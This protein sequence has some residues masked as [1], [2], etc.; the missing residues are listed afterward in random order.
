VASATGSAGFNIPPGAAPTTPVNGDIWETSAGIFAR[1]NGA[2]VGPLISAASIPSSLPPNGSAGGDL[3]GSYP[4]PTLAWLSRT[5]GKT[6]AIAASL[7]L[8]GTDGSTL[9]VG[10]GGTLGSNAF[11]STAFAPIAS[12]TFTGTPAAPT[13]ALR[14]S[15]TQIAT[16]AFVMQNEASA[17]FYDAVAQSGIDNTGAADVGATINS[18]FATHPCIALQP[19]TYKTSVAIVI[20]TLC[21]LVGAGIGKTIITSTSTT[22]DVVR[23]ADGGSYMLARDFS[24]TRSVTPTNGAGFAWGTGTIV[25]ESSAYNI[26]SYGNFYGFR[27]MATDWS[28]MEYC[29]AY[30]N[31]SHGFYF[32]NP[33]G[34]GVPANQTFQYQCAHC[35]SFYN[36]GQGYYVE[37]VSGSTNTVFGGFTCMSSFANTG[38]GYWF[39]AASGTQITNITLE[40]CVGSSDGND[41]IHLDTRGGWC[42][43][44]MG[45]YEQAGVGALTGSG[46]NTALSH[47]GAG[48]DV[49][50]QTD[51]SVTGVR[52]FWANSQDGIVIQSG[53]GASTLLVTTSDFV[54]NGQTTANTYKGISNGSSTLKASLIGNTFLDATWQA[55]GWGSVAGATCYMFGNFATGATGGAAGGTLLPATGGAQT[56]NT[57]TG[58][59]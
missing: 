49:V 56:Y 5:A 32:T 9:N 6:L 52:R 58:M 41:E 43:I 50:S 54:A 7:T 14:T 23:F 33:G 15:T 47:V 16:T 13:A 17:P 11:T 35:N 36:D 37:A 26:Y 48:I 46:R 40:N 29:V 2:T 55:F 19:G 59:P 42:A 25:I 28:L 53:A 57:G 20:P 45:L 3:A 51:L 1:V 31:K 34:S 8:A 24:V 22:L 44:T 39:V 30:A 4:N 21:S 12:P 10:A 38:G 27:M 18:L